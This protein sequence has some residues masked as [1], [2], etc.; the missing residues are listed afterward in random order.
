M[1]SF[2]RFYS[3][4]YPPKNLNEINSNR[5]MYFSFDNKDVFIL[6]SYRRACLNAIIDGNKTQFQRVRHFRFSLVYVFPSSNI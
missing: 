5:Y 2:T 6:N 3:K 4:D 1:L